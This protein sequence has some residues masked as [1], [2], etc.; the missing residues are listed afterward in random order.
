VPEPAPEPAPES[1]P[2]PPATIAESAPQTDSTETAPTILKPG[3]E[4]ETLPSNEGL[5]SL[6]PNVKVNR[7]PTIGAETPDGQETLVPDDAAAVPATPGDGPALTRFAVPFANPDKRPMMA[8]VLLDEGG[9]RND[10]A[11]L[12]A[13]PFPVTLA[14]DASRPDAAAAMTDFRSIGREVVAIAPLPSGASPTDVE[15]ALESYGTAV[16]EAVA[17]MDMPD[18]AFQ[19]SRQVATQV[20]LILKARGQGMITYSRGLNSAT[21]VA[22]REG[23]PAQ[24]VFRDFDSDGQ[25]SAAIKRFLDQAAFRAGQQSGVILVG[26]NRPETIAALVEWGLGIRAATVALAPVSA[27]LKPQ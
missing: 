14:V 11:A 23:V 19:S 22:E 3:A 2:E 10:L 6:A 17:L 1:T 27:V 24:L 16:P 8:I 5:A 18:G 13:L 25:D 4:P 21:Q 7:L 26:H 20:A 9:P 12:G 15:V